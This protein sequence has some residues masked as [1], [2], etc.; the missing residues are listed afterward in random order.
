MKLLQ[1]SRDCKPT[2]VYRLKQRRTTVVYT[3]DERQNIL[4]NKRACFS[5]LEIGHNSKRCKTKLK[6]IVCSK[7][8]VS[9][10][11]S[12]LS[13]KRYGHR[14]YVLNKNV[15]EQNLSLRVLLDILMYF[16]KVLMLVVN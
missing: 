12:I 14:E 9:L 8:H 2:F 13:E 5:C 4:K 10:M 11:C 3:V 1:F 6:Y 16:C 15:R 7:H